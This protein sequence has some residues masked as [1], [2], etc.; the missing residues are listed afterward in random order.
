[1]PPTA[2]SS[3]CHDARIEQYSVRRVSRTSESGRCVV[4]PR[5]G[6]TQERQTEATKILYALLH[7]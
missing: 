7:Y 6:P 3:A 4:R 5:Q 2:A 1:M